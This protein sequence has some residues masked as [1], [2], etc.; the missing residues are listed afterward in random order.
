MTATKLHRTAVDRLLA[1][2]KELEKE[3]ETLRYDNTHYI[4]PFNK[5]IEYFSS[6]FISPITFSTGTQIIEK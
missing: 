2:F 1:S 3:V 6:E 4:I 5:I